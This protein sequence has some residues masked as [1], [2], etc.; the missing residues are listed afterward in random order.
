[1]GHVLGFKDLD[2]N[3][4]NLMRWTLDAGTRR[5]NIS[6]PESPKLVQ[7]DRA[8][9]SE[10]ASMLWGAKENKA[11]WLEDFLADIAGKKN[12][13]FDPMDKIKI[14]IPGISGGDNKKQN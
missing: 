7:M 4:Q 8:P 13:P 2:P 6:T 9:G 3:A 5:L 1:M 12:N 10:M 14:S 11:S